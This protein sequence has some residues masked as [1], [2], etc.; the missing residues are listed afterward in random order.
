M[1]NIILNTDPVE[2]C[3]KSSFCPDIEEPA[4][5]FTMETEVL[6]IHDRIGSVGIGLDKLIFDGNH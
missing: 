3:N 5:T 4:N 6:E 2:G 1:I